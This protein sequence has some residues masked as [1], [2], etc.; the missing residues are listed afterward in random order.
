MS[1]SHPDTSTLPPKKLETKLSKEKEERRRESRRA[2]S[3]RYRERHRAQVLEAGRIRAAQRCHN[4]KKLSGREYLAE[5]SRLKAREASAR[6]RAENREA[7]ALQERQRRKR[8]FI[9]KY[10]IHAYIQRRFDAPIPSCEPD[11]DPEDAGDE[12]DDLSW[13]DIG[14]CVSALICD[15]IDPCL[16]R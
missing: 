1:R 13:G 16:K 5:R 7:L 8:A 15:Y 6:Y 4:L 3:A 2:A 12:N 14:P 10:G 9:D 11:S